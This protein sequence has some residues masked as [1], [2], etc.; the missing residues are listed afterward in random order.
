MRLAALAS[1]A[2][3]P[4]STGAQPWALYAWLFCGARL[5]APSSPHNYNSLLLPPLPPPCTA[6]GNMAVTPPWSIL[7]TTA[8]P[9]RCC[10]APLV[11]AASP[12]EFYG[13]LTGANYYSVALV[14]ASFC[15]PGVTLASLKVRH[16]SIYSRSVVCL[17]H[18]WTPPSALLA[19]P[20]PASR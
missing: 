1:A 5:H 15:T 17:V 8:P 19:S 13:A 11:A 9:Q 2:Q 4:S 20:S 12:A 6:R 14:D 16:S 10:P 7:L 3:H 18:W